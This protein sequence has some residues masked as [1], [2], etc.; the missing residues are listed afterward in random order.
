MIYGWPGL[1]QLWQKGHVGGM[2]SALLFTMMLNLGLITHWIWPELL[3]EPWKAAIWPLVAVVW[4][5]LVG[6]ALWRRPGGPH[7]PSDR[8]VGLFVSAQGEYLRGNWTEAETLLRKLLRHN[9]D[10][11][12]ARLLLTGI[13][14]RSGRTEE[15]RR[16]LRRLARLEAADAWRLEIDRELQWIDTRQRKAESNEQ[17]EL[18]TDQDQDHYKAA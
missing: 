5:P 12:E 6:W 10:D 11:V 15:A 9:H 16:Q 2:V 8:A 3:A 18:E 14:R 7:A 13:F 17:A 1:P 4:M